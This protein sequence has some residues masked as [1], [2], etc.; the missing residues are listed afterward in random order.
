MILHS[1]TLFCIFI[2]VSIFS[3]G[4]LAQSQGYTCDPSQCKPP[5]CLCAS[6]NPPGGLA[7]SNTPQF[8]TLTFDDS[9]Q[10]DIIKTAYT[11]LNRKNPN[12]CPARGTWFVSI[13]YTDMQL[14]TEWY[15]NGNEVADHT[16]THPAQPSEQEIGSCKTILNSFA[17]IPRSKIKGF[18]APFLNYTAETLNNVKKQGFVYDSSASAQTEDAYWPYTLDYGLANDCWSSANLCQPGVLK[19]PG[20]WEIPMHSIVDQQKLPHVMDPHLAGTT[21]TVLQWLKDNFNRHYNGGRQPFGLYVHPAHLTPHPGAPDP[22]ANMAMLQNFLNWVQT[23]PDVY[24]VTN[25]QLLQWVQNP[26]PKDQVGSQLYMRCTN[27]QVAAMNKDNSTLA[28]AGTQGICN[29][30]NSALAELCIFPDGQWRTCYGCPARMPT[31]DDPVPPRAAASAARH[32]VPDDCDTIY[33]DPI[34]NKCTCT[35]PEC[36]FKDIAPQI[37]TT[38]S[39]A[40]KTSEGNRPRSDIVSLGMIF[41]TALISSILAL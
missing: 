36:A 24:F 25:E 23:M 32:P 28:V 15:A 9:V 8:V 21:D 19:I 33:W 13:Q 6:T 35:G 38:N 10:N 37:S 31:V 14:V 16:F 11:L 1:R 2:I 39:I 41:A 30:L 12:G 3:L 17:G 29:G 18:R 5:N 26:V 20:L 34:G 40:T 4:G 27:S 22:S 7:P